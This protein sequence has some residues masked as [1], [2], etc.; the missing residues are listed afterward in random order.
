MGP[1]VFALETKAQDEKADYWTLISLAEMRVLTAEVA[2]Q[3]TRAYRKALTASRRNQFYLQSSLGQLEILQSLDMRGEFVQ[4]G[5]NAINE[6]LRRIRKEIVTE[7]TTAKKGKVEP[8]V[9][10]PAPKN[11]GMVFLFTGYMISNP[12]KKENQFPPEK[13]KDIRDAI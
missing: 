11:Q 9:A 6:E 10:A 2:Q 1:L 13:E 12:K 8:V 7:E 3:V 5:I 4:A